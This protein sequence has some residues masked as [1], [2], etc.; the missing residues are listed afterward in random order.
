M[1]IHGCNARYGIVKKNKLS[2]LDRIKKFF[3]NK[4][5][6]YEYVYGSHEM[7]KGSD[8]NGFYST[9][10]W[11]TV[12]ENN[13][14][15]ERLWNYS[16]K[17]GKDLLGEGIILY[18]EI[19]GPGIQ[20]YYTYNRD[21]LGIL[22]F[23][24]KLKG[25]YLNDLDF[26]TVVVDNLG[27]PVVNVLYEGK[28]NKEWIENKFKNW[29]IEGTKVSHEGIICKSPSGDRS[30]IVKYIKSSIFRISK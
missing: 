17:L 1:K 10:V 14:F 27:L 15:K 24:I 11:R 2:F 7:E 3:G 20:K 5:I 12:A 19:Y 8:T 6:E 29:F 18:G 22:F 9:D 13:N 4:W 25:N 21:N 26:L 23:D 28:F 30:K 16:K